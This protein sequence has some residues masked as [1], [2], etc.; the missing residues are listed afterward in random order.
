M[1]P[2]TGTITEVS[3]LQVCRFGRVVEMR[4]RKRVSISKNHFKFMSGHSTM[5][6]FQLVRIP[7][8]KYRERK[9]DLHKVFINLEKGL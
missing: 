9:T 5:V 4:V 3:K 1:I 6:P 2:K 7:V 8:E